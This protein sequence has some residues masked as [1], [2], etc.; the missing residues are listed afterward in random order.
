[1]TT[2]PTRT[3]TMRPNSLRTTTPDNRRD[4]RNHT[5]PLT[6]STYRTIRLNPTTTRLTALPR[7]PSNI[8][9]RSSGM[10]RRGRP[11]ISQSHHP[12]LY[13]RL[14]S[15]LPRSTDQNPRPHLPPL[16]LPLRH[17]HLRLRPRP[18]LSAYM[19]LRPSR[20]PTRRLDERRGHPKPPTHLPNINANRGRKKLPPLLGIPHPWRQ[21]PRWILTL[22]R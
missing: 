17:R 6:P 18:P 5:R 4:L 15:L 19:R 11:S 9:H 14:L 16:P 21:Q 10:A 8:R 1:M 13:P 3:T 22:E 20:T 2:R 7:T 12:H